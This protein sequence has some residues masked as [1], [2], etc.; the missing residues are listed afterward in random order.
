[1]KEFIETNWK[2]IVAFFDKLYAIIKQILIEA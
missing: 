2:E 1:M